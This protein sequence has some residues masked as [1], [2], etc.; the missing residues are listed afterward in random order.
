MPCGAALLATPAACTMHHHPTSQ[1]L[2]HNGL[3]PSSARPLTLD[4]ARRR[5]ELVYPELVGPAPRA[6][7]VVFGVEVGGRW[8]RESCI[9]VR[10]LARARARAEVP[11]LRASAA[12]AWQRR[13]TAMLAVA[14]QRAVAASLLERAGT[15]GADGTFGND[16]WPPCNTHCVIEDAAQGLV[17]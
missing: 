3:S 5:K 2:A 11:G 16:T 15:C 1:S 13:W 8:S 17:K 9:F 4:T 6:R 14:A 12:R 7:L 10:L